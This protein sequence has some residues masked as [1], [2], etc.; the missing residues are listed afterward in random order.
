MRKGDKL[1]LGLVIGFF[2]P[3]LGLLGHYFWKASSWKLSEYW[4]MVLNNRSFFTAVIS[5]SM[6]VNVILFTIFVNTRRDKTAKGIFAVT[7]LYAV[8]ALI[9]KFAS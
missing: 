9:Y 7:V 4:N 2:A 1:W 5:I 8:A 3:V 6:F